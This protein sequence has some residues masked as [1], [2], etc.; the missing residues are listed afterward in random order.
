[1]INWQKRVFKM[2]NML[3]L[4]VTIALLIGA[5]SIT[6]INAAQEKVTV[7][8]WADGTVGTLET[9]KKQE[10]GF[11]KVYP[12]I[13]INYEEFPNSQEKVLAAFAV[14]RPPDIFNLYSR[15]IGK[16]MEQNLLLPITPAAIT[17]EE[18][19]EILFCPPAGKSAY[20]GKDGEFYGIPRQLLVSHGG[21]VLNKKLFEEAGL[22]QYPQTWKDFMMAAQKMTKRN[23]EGK[24]VVAGMGRTPW[25]FWATLWS[26]I[27]QHGGEYFDEENQEFNYASPEAI[28]AIKFWKENYLKVNGLEILSDFEEFCKGRVGMLIVQPWIWGAI[29][30]AAP[31]LVGN[32]EYLR[33]PPIDVKGLPGYVILSEGCGYVIPADTKVPDAALTFVLWAATD[34]EAGLIFQ[35]AFAQL[36]CLKSIWETDEFTKEGEIRYFTKAVLDVVKN[37]PETHRWVPTIARVGETQS[38]AIGVNWEKILAG[39]V[40]VEEGSKQMTDDANRIIRG[41]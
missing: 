37:Q 19:S 40:S 7:T 33:V 18:L 6:G 12:N 5:F 32:V 34:K 23:E 4:V 2:Q 20:R 10:E 29:P 31:N 9:F 24:V 3:V 13:K 35:R 1:M 15:Y 27:L 30:D 17:A 21:Y 39:E 26:L 16:F 38:D 28:Q 11:Y 14:G 8:Y 36:P 25:D 41:R 22:G